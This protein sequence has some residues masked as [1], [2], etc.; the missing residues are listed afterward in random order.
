MGWRW[1]LSSLDSSG[2]PDA[3][4]IWEG[5]LPV[6]LTVVDLLGDLWTVGSSEEQTHQWS[7]QAVKQ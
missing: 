6:A 4:V 1:V 7:V 3:V 5:P 2:F